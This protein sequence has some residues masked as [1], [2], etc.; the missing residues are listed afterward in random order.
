M[1]VTFTVRQ[2]ALPRLSPLAETLVAAALAALGYFALQGELPYHDAAR[3]TDQLASGGF[4]WD[5]AHI[6]LQPSALLLHRW[7]GAAPGETLKAFSSLSAAAAVGLFHLLLLRLDVPRWQAVL[8]TLLLGGCCSV[9]TL[10]PSAH[11]KLVAFPFVTGALLCLCM[12]ER[13]GMRNI[14]LLVLGAVLLALGAGFLASALATAPFAALAVL[15]GSRRAGGS[16]T[17]ALGRALI[18]GGTCGLVFLVIACAGFVLLTGEPLGLAGLT[19]SVAGKAEL[20]PAP[21]SLMVHLARL[22]FG[23]VNNLIALPDLGATMQAWMRGQIPSLWPYIGLLPIMLLW[24]SGG[25]LIAAIYVRTAMALLRGCRCLVPAAFLCGATAWTIW[26]GLNDP[27]HWFQ[28]TAPTIV[29]FLTV[30]PMNVVRLVLPSWAAIATA[31]NLS[32]LAVPV[33]TYPLA[34]NSAELAGMLGPNDLLVLFAAYPGRPYAGFFDLPGIHELPVDLGLRAPGTTTEAALDTISA[35]LDETLK[36]GGRVLVADLLD[37]RDWEAPW[38]ALLSEGVTK[39]RLY[40]FLLASRVPIRLR[41]VGGVKLWELS[42]LPP[43]A[44]GKSL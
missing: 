30:M 11:P 3:F 42:P 6:L 17:A 20:R 44:P 1:S 28:L 24:L 36:A 7:S 38:A 14:A 18:V 13:G 10:A 40:R 32:L 37:P 16:W 4:V 2:P 34:R 35:T 12:A 23:T 21:A 15:V 22:L 33:A 8:G 5:I 43:P 31:V 9:L 27:E 39:E 29:L 25:L 19:H 41:D 26:Y